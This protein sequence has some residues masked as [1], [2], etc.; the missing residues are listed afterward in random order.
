MCKSGESVGQAVFIRMPRLSCVYILD[1]RAMAIYF[2]ADYSDILGVAAVT[3]LHVTLCLPLQNF[4]ENVDYVE[5]CTLATFN[6]L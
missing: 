1:K 3:M 6:N 2:N 4:K 5:Q